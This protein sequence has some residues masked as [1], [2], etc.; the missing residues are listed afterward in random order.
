MSF[1]SALQVACYACVEAFSH[2]TLYEADLVAKAKRL[3]DV[4]KTVVADM[5]LDDSD[6]QLVCS[7]LYFIASQK[8]NRPF[9]QSFT[10]FP[11]TLRTLMS[12][13]TMECS[14][15]EESKDFLVALKCGVDINCKRFV[16]E[17][18]ARIA[19]A[20]EA[21]RTKVESEAA[22]LV[23]A[24]VDQG[25]LSTIERTPDTVLP[26]H[27]VPSSTHPSE[28]E[29]RIRHRRVTAKYPHC[30]AEVPR[31][32]VREG[33]P[34]L[35]FKCVVR[36]G[37]GATQVT[38]E[39]K[40]QGSV[41]SAFAEVMALI[42]RC[43]HEQP[44]RASAIDFGSIDEK[45]KPS[46]VEMKNV[47]PVGIPRYM[48][49]ISW[50]LDGNDTRTT[51]QHSSMQDAILEV[52]AIVRS[53]DE[54]RK[55]ATSQRTDYIQ[56]LAELGFL[57]GNVA[58]T[59]KESG[60][61]ASISWD[62]GDGGRGTWTG[63]RVWPDKQ[64]AIISAASEA[65]AGLD[66][67]E[68]DWTAMARKN[69]LE[70]APPGLHVLVAI[71]NDGGFEAGAFW[72]EGR[73]YVVWG[74]A[75]ITKG[76]AVHSLCEQLR[77]ALLRR[78]EL[79]KLIAASG[80]NSDKMKKL[81]SLLQEMKPKWI[82]EK[83]VLMKQ[84]PQTDKITERIRAI[85]NLLALCDP[86][87]RKRVPESVAERLLSATVLEA[88]EAV[89]PTTI[90]LTSSDQ[91]N[92]LRSLCGGG[93]RVPGTE[94]HRCEE[95]ER[96]ARKLKLKPD[97]LVTDLEGLRLLNKRVNGRLTLT[98]FGASLLRS[99]EPGGQISQKFGNALAAMRT[100]ASGWR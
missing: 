51:A 48:C 92:I 59:K 76:A 80:T 70:C 55:Q 100:T 43:P 54:A 2:S 21:Y 56:I 17:E 38:L 44:F 24:V 57:K 26:D 71:A 90:A 97:A 30:A 84:N 73:S 91:V 58:F 67:L 5:E 99:A 95:F 35:P 72:K 60:W 40:F 85:S 18:P 64:Q 89:L 36:W 8:H 37:H 93:P 75:R 25:L 4:C 27:W 69:L 81:E 13:A 77:P 7:A 65:R 23:A 33:N 11:A 52:V 88:Y 19:A 9:D 66:D 15:R 10:Q 53:R 49:S 42:E 78:A 22:A 98:D 45:S 82:A 3:A 96:A 12:L 32:H 29:D 39:S 6:H 61:S 63:Q 62:R 50:G 74:N 68:M 34:T 41:E 94:L 20:A 1:T 87:Q 86:I 28:W 83:A 46:R 47:T 79:R 31:F 16:D 14:F